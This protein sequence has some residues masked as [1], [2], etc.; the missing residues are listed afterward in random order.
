[1]DFDALMDAF[2]T[3]Q[4]NPALMQ[5]SNLQA[6][7]DALDTLTFIDEVIAHNPNVVELTAIKYEVEQLRKQLE[8]INSQVFLE[9]RELIK[10][11]RKSGT[12]LRTLFNTFTDYTPGKSQHIHVDYEALDVLLAGTLLPSQSPSPELKLSPEMVQWEASPGSAILDLIDHVTLTTDDVFYDLGSGLGNVA[13]LVNLLSGVKTVGVERD[14]AYWQYAS[15]L[16]KEYSLNN[17]RFINADAREIDYSD[18]T[19][20]YLFTPFIASVLQTVMGKIRQAA[21]QHPIH[22]CS[23]GPCTPEIAQ[24]SWLHNTNGDREHEFKLAIFESVL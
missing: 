5:K 13:I 23:F 7:A 4:A 16:V 3:L 11:N 24:L 12:T 18:G 20:F 2:H 19:V 14:P 17:V 21:L 1:M 6:R 15:N 8:F 10:T 9:T 22:V